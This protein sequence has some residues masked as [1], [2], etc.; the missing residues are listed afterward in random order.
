M[1]DKTIGELKRATSLD[2]DSLLIA[3]QQGE[4]VSLTGSLFKQF[5]EDA[6]DEQ[7]GA[8]KQY[9]ENAKQSAE[10]AKTAVGG[11]GNAVE[12]TKNNAQAAEDARK[13]IE[14]MVVEAVTLATGTPAS[15]T[16]ELINGVVKLVFGLPSGDKGDKGDPGNSIQSITRTAGNGEPGTT[17]TYTITF[18][19]GST[20]AFYVYNG[21]DGVGSGDMAASV[22]DP[23]G[24]ATDIFKYVDDVL[25]TIPNPDVS[26]QIGTHNTD[27]A[28]HGDIRAAIPTKTSDLANDSGF[29]TDYAETDPTV[30][31]WAKEASKPT[32]TASE[33]GAA[34][35]THTHTAENITGGTLAGE[36]AAYRTTNPSAYNIRNSVVISAGVGAVNPPNNGEIAWLYG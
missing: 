2:D 27:T 29:I 15:V 26:G 34:P 24:K 36:V 21:K 19:D 16:K 7:V 32:Y 33:V 12:D 17:D 23:Q 3:E 6:A 35:T 10:E 31:A 13:A 18:T 9:A 20:M 28:A 25:T 11:I 4:A 22:Y 14:D 8:A 30:P 5:V 1:A